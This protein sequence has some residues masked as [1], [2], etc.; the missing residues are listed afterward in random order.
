LRP[1]ANVKCG[2]C[3]VVADGA[4]GFCLLLPH[5]FDVVVALVGSCGCGREN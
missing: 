5:V 2:F 1:F 4:G 3:K